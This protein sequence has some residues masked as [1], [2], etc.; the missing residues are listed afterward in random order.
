M[1]FYKINTCSYRL[2]K[3]RKSLHPELVWGH[4]LHAV[5]FLF[6]HEF[7]VAYQNL[8]MKASS[9]DISNAGNI[10]RF[11]GAINCICPLTWQKIVFFCEQ[12]AIKLEQLGPVI[13][14][15]CLTKQLQMLAN[16]ELLMDVK[17][18]DHSVG[19]L[20]CFYLSLYV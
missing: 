12:L 11:L 15:P 5:G 16:F 3:Y 19:F 1:Q 17:H 20:I 14:F 9:L 13:L 4:N 10:F 18:F 8:F 7:L 6:E 2:Q